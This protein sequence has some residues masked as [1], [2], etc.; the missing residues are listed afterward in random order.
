MKRTL[1]LKWPE[2]RTT[3]FRESG[4]P[5]F[6]FSVLSQAICIRHYPPT[7][8]PKKSLIPC[9]SH[10][11]EVFGPALIFS[12]GRHV[13]MHVCPH[14]HS[15]TSVRMSSLWSQNGL[16]LI[17]SSATYQLDNGDKSMNISKT[18]FSFLYNENIT[19]I[20]L[21]GTNMFKKDKSSC[22]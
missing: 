9:T 17:P 10:I 4:L 18:C 19:I 11:S 14:T 8:H 21:S 16:T 12:V 5:D 2:C 15:S 3:I 22:Y 20:F 13:P 1:S 6:T 7:T